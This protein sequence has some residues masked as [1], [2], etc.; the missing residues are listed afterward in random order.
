MTRI[1]ARRLA[2]SL[3][4]CAIDGANWPAALLDDCETDSARVQEALA[5]L[6]EEMDRRATHRPRAQPK[7]TR[8]V[9]STR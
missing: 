5:Q 8:R 6:S 7:N 2:C 4:A 9:A 3:A 1:E